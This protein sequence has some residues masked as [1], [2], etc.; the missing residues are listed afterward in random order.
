[1]DA[2]GAADAA[3]GNGFRIYRT[4]RKR[5]RS[6]PL[7]SGVRML[8]WWGVWSAMYG[9]QTLDQGWNVASNAT[10]SDVVHITDGKTLWNQPRQQWVGIVVATLDKSG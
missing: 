10:G 2:I 9:V 5:D 1:M 8:V 3:P 6:Y 4:N 7:G